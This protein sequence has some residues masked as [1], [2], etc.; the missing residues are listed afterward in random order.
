MSYHLASDKRPPGRYRVQ[1]QPY[2]GVGDTVR[3]MKQLAVS[4]QAHPVVRRAAIAAIRQVYPKDY[5]S[6]LAAIYY[7][8]CRSIR[9]TRDPAGREMLQHPAVTV[10]ERAGD[11]DDHGILLNALIRAARTGHPVDNVRAL[12]GFG[13]RAL[14]V[15]NDLQFVIAGFE[16]NAPMPRR[17]THVF[18]RV[19]DNNTGRWLV[20]DPVA[21]P[22][23]G[24][25]IDRVKVY[26]GY[27][28]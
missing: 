14:A 24:S 9:Y 13:A 22:N 1:V 7:D 28:A 18:L 21:G 20:L 17:Y 27:W 23:T 19:Y 5:T 26:R 16:K 15:G 8:T 3:Y 11:C 12:T 10:Q 6:E 25:M 2:H 4:G